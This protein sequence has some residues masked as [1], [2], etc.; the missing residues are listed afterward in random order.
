MAGRLRQQGY[1]VMVNHNGGSFKSQFKKAD[2]S[3]ARIALILG[4][5]EMVEGVVTLKHLREDKPQVKVQFAKIEEQLDGN[6]T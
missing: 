1:K 2:K 3:G 5:T 6:T 4:E